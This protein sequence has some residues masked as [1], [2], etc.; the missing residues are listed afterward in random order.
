[1]NG[2]AFLYDSKDDIGAHHRIELL[3]E[4]A[5]FQQNAIIL[6]IR[7]KTLNYTKLVLLPSPS[8]PY[9]YP[10]NYPQLPA[11]VR[12]AWTLAENQNRRWRVGVGKDL[13]RIA[14]KRKAVAV[15]RL[16]KNA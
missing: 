9:N 10:Q 1:M 12:A 11:T 6:D 15:D 7:R 4:T 8:F 5:N 14:V 2:H 16:T 3:E 13:R